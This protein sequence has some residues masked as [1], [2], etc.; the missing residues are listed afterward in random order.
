MPGVEDI[1]DVYESWMRSGS[2]ELPEGQGAVSDIVSAGAY[3]WTYEY[4]GEMLYG[5]VAE[6]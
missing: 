6:V 3:V 4:E 5:T 2:L 1:G